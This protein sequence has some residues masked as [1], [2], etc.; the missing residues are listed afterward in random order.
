M[1]YF[2]DEWDYLAKRVYKNACD[3]GFWVNRAR[4]MD[5]CGAVGVSLV[6]SQMIALQMTELGEAIEAL[7]KGGSQ[8][9]ENLPDFL[10]I[11]V[12]LADTVIRIMDHGAAFNYRIAEAIQAKIA[13]N[14]TREYKHGKAF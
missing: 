9:D 12:E 14:E 10:S 6:E 2:R 11:E 8:A 5:L 1:S 13:Y 4:A 3:K 7:R